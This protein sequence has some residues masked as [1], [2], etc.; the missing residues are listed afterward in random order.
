[1]ASCE[2]RID[3]L[4]F[5][6]LHGSPEARKQQVYVDARTGV[7]GCALWLKGVRPE[8]F[9]LR[10]G[11]DVESFTG[12]ANLYKQYRELI[13]TDPVD[14]VWSGWD[15]AVD[16]Y[17]VCV[18]DVRR[19]DVSGLLASVGGINPPSAAWLECDWDLIAV[20]IEED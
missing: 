8:K 13:G 7:E 16:G 5:V 15:S 19:V 12:A 3:D 9:T 20:P 14:L 1:M 17:R 2:H 11:V 6:W 18:L 10:S 4:Y